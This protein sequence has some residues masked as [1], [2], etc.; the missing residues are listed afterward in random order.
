LWRDGMRGFKKE[1]KG[2]IK[3]ELRRDRKR[4]YRKE[5]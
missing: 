1:R 4:G 3:E 5:K 2:K